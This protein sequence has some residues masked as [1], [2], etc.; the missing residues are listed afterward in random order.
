MLEQ[1]FLKEQPQM[2]VTLWANAW[3]QA[4]LRI[5]FTWKGCSVP[6]M[7]LRLARQLG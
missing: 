6:G 1:P 4:A 5:V 3:A 7:V 2:E